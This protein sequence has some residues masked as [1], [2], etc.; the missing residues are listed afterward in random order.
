MSDDTAAG[1]QRKKEGERARNLYPVMEYLDPADPRWREPGFLRVFCE[2]SQFFSAAYEM[3]IA[4]LGEDRARTHVLSLVNPSSLRRTKGKHDARYNVELVITY[5]MATEGQK[6][7]AIKKVMKRHGRATNPEQVATAL[8][9]CQRIQK[10]GL[11]LEE[12]Q[13]APPELVMPYV[14]QRQ[15]AF[16]EELEAEGSASAAYIAAQVRELQKKPPDN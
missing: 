5:E 6:T 1:R 12:L 16:L 8:R 11:T 13:A 7:E 9:Q 2:A 4:L 10:R 3:L 15:N 14:N